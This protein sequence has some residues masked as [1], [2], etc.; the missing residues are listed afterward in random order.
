[1]REILITLI[2]NLLFFGSIAQQLEQLNDKK[3]VIE[4][5]FHTIIK[6]MPSPIEQLEA[7]H[8]DKVKFN[9]HLLSPASNVQHFESDAAEAIN[10]GIYMV[11]F[12][13]L[14]V[15]QEQ[16]KMMQYRALALELAAKI[17]AN[18]P[19]HKVLGIDLENKVKDYDVLKKAIIDALNATENQLIDNNHIATAS[20]MLLG[21]WIETQYIMLQ[22]F[23]RD[24]KPS[25][26]VKQHIV[27]QQVHLANLIKLVHEFKDDAGFHEE[28]E[29]LNKLEDSLLKIHNI[30]GVTETIVL[31]L[32]DEITRL[33][34]DILAME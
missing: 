28:L 7:L 10:C 24:K 21:S 5:E 2:A 26:Q 3:E 29:K 8:N 34:M 17:E 19:F 15:F 16:D 11:D 4:N 14:A 27:D 23:I 6:S 32:V 20:Q 9:E 30:E 18:K 25:S 13:Y 12:A 31:K 1:M 22:S 33:R